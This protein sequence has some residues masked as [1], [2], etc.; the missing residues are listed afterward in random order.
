MRWVQEW[1]PSPLH[2]KSSYGLTSVNPETPPEVG[3]PPTSFNT[4]YPV[5]QQRCPW[6]M[7][8]KTH[9][10]VLLICLCSREWL[11]EEMSWW[12]ISWCSLLH[13]FLA[14]F[15]NTQ[16][17]FLRLGFG[18]LGLFFPLLTTTALQ[19][20]R[21]HGIC[22]LVFS[23][24]VASIQHKSSSLDNQRNHFSWWD[25]KDPGRWGIYDTF[26]LHTI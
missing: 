17:I 2:G 3:V 9:H 1:V 26:L 7:H 18:I 23:C 11:E 24:S 10:F 22:V 13:F 15:A 19:T 20:S 14:C 4:F 6:L 8:R 16:L 25:T 5:H 12:N 21:L